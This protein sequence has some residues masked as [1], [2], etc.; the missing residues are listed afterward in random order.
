MLCPGVAQLITKNPVVLA[1]ANKIL[2]NDSEFMLAAI[3]I[4]IESL[5]YANTEL[6][7]SR[8]FIQRAMLINYKAFNYA[9]NKE[10]LEKSELKRSVLHYQYSVK[11]GSRFHLFAANLKNDEQLEKTYKHKTGDALKTAILKAFKISLEGKN[12]SEID[13]QVKAFKKSKEYEVL[14][15]SQGIT[16]RLFKLH[17]TSA[18][19]VEQIIE[20]ARM[21]VPSLDISVQ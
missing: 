17:T 15:T 9:C 12:S 5:K 8:N 6:L 14:C 3:K 13:E 2:I 7:S 21:V 4:N 19:S 16:S 10:F 20:D 18:R 1:S 11:T